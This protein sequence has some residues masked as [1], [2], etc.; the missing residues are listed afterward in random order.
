MKVA[1]AIDNAHKLNVRASILPLSLSFTLFFYPAVSLW[2]FSARFARSLRRT[3]AP[4]NRAQ[5]DK[6]YREPIV[7][8]DDRSAM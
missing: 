7:R 3:R 8:G 5:L 4:I 1:R 6:S 2:G